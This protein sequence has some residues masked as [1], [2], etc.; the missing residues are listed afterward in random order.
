MSGASV[1]FALMGGFTKLAT[2]VIPHSPVLPGS[3]I[4]LVRYLCGLAFLV[5]YHLRT[6][7]DMLGGDRRGLL[8]RG[9]H[10]GVASV[11]F[12]IGIQRTTLIHATLLNYTSVVWGPLFATYVLGERLDRRAAT[13]LTIALAGVVLITH[14]QAG[15][16]SYGDIV[17][18]LSGIIS[19][20]AL[21]Q[22][23]RLRQGES[24]F[25]VF[26]YFNLVGLPC[27]LLALSITG[28]HLTTPSLVQLPVLLGVGATSVAAQMLMTYSYK[29]V[30]TMQG[31]LINLSTIVYAAVI[32]TVCFHDPFTTSTL[33][34]GLLVLCS[35]VIFFTRSARR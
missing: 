16:F 22:I 5:A 3:E 11:L 8:W 28:T 29:E 7:E 31:G 18:L 25:A 20:A 10:G 23:R 6:S 34:G 30:T 17:A 33:L 4:A 12:F 14:P 19:G 35:A 27:A 24:A 1:S 13:A 21:V 15:R 32:N 2:R 9:I 26:F